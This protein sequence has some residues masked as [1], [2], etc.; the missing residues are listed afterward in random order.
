MRILHV[1]HS[2]NPAGGGPIEAVKQ[3]AAVHLRDG[4][5]VEVVTLDDETAPWNAEAEL[6]IHPLGS[7]VPGYGFSPKLI[8][9]LRKRARDFDIVV[10]HGLWLFN[11]LAV[12][13]ALRGSETPYCVFPHGML[14]PWFKRRYPLKHA[15]KWLY[16]QAVERRVLRDADAVL[17]T[18]EEE[19]VQARQSFS[20]YRCNEIV[21]SFGTARPTG[22]AGRQR[23][24]FLQ[25]FPHLSGK[26]L[27][28]FLGRVHEKK[29]CR[30]LIEAFRRVPANGTPGDFHLV[31]AGPADNA[32]GREL[33]EA[34][35]HHGSAGAVTWT[36]MLG[37]DL[38]WG[39]FHSAEAFVLPSHQENFGIAVA[40]ALACG[41]PV[42]ISN[43]VNIW[44]EI[45]QDRAGL[46]E[47][48]DLEGTARLLQ[49]WA[50][51]DASART[52]MQSAARGCF[53]ARFEMEKAA[54]D[55]V[56]VFQ[57]V[58]EGRRVAC[59]RA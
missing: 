15:K 37:G 6:R 8:P 57:R 58:I 11:G 36:G 55:L 2:A 18:C 41:V 7:S 20:P 13:Q 43:K 54:R 23:E 4:H 53:A 24:T 25:K 45:E 21:V 47:N 38:K 49:R 33:T 34:T 39:A 28:L 3:L 16:W 42:L 40:E 51:L 12:W 46:I 48:D 30:E 5:G 32:Y 59:S 31:M 35:A 10:S 56:E 29:G 1:I 52:E 50:A 19:R 14:D 27:L 9:W 44:R 17:F 26:R 22:E